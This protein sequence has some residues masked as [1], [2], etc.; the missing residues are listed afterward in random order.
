MLNYPTRKCWLKYTVRMS[1]TQQYHLNV[2][3][4]LQTSLG[5]VIENISKKYPYIVMVEDD[6]IVGYAYAGR[7]KGRKAYDWCVET[8]IYVRED[9]KGGG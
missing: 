5:V 9:K 7:F 1:K 8:T 2:K 4:R 3:R 6:E